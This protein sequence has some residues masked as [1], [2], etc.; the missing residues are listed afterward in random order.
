[1]VETIT[2]ENVIDPLETI[3]I[4]FAPPRGEIFIPGLDIPGQDT[5]K[6]NVTLK[7]SFKEKLSKQ[8]VL[9]NRKN[10]SIQKIYEK[11]E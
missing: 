1:M 2:L 4:F 3:D 6:D 10:G 9:I 7:P 8:L 11:T 5:G